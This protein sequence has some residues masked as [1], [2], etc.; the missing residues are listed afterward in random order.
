MLLRILNSTTRPRDRGTPLHMMLGRNSNG[1]MPNQA[2]AKFDFLN[3]YRVRQQEA[4][5]YAKKRVCTYRY[6]FQ[7]GNHVVLQDIFSKE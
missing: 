4:N 3:N 2:N 7:K 5:K 1:Y 6:D